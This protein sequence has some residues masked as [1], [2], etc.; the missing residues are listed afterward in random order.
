MNLTIDADLTNVSGEPAYTNYVTGFCACLDYIYADSH[1][2]KPVRV[3]LM[4][5]HEEVI[6]HTA[7]PN[8]VFPSDHLP[9]ICDL[10]WA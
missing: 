10:G 2:L 7:L 6:Q 3:I 5:S 4:P 1:R 9:V 8:V